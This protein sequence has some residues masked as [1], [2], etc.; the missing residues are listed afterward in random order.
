MILV[1]FCIFWPTESGLRFSISDSND[2]GG[3][4]ALIKKNYNAD[5]L[6]LNNKTLIHFIK[7]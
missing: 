3:I 7:R 6:H 1:G 2:Q 4:H 5:L